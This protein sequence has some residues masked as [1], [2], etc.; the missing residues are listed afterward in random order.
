MARFPEYKA[1]HPRSRL[2]RTSV[3]EHTTVSR[4]RSMQRRKWVAL[5]EPRLGPAVRGWFAE[6]SGDFPFGDGIV[7]LERTGIP[8]GLDGA[9]KAALNRTSAGRALTPHDAPGI[10]SRKM[11]ERFWNLFAPRRIPTAGAI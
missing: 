2:S 11:A 8:S 5:R 7:K 4:H 1:G 9:T 3:R 6:C 10:I